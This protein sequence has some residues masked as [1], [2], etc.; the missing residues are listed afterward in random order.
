MF[1]LVNILYFHYLFI[2][3]WT[4]R[5]FRL[6]LIS[7]YYEQGIKYYWGI[8]QYLSWAVGS[9]MCRCRVALATAGHHTYKGIKVFAKMR[10]WEYNQSDKRQVNQSDERQVNQS[11]ERQVNQSDVGM[12]MRW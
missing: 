4:P 8:Q 11:D 1:H 2:S 9:H 10:F 6:F 12:Q 5:I 7:D 3:W